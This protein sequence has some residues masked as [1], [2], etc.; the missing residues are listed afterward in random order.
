MLGLAGHFA[1]LNTD[2]HAG[3]G[4][5]DGGLC[6]GT[7]AIG[8]TARGSNGN[9]TIS[10]VEGKC[11]EVNTGIFK[12]ILGTFDRPVEGAR[13]SRDDPQDLPGWGVEG[14]WAFGGIQH[15]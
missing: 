5:D 6:Q 13:A 10:A 7:E 9:N 1:L 8:R 11:F 2:H 4:T 14:W 15:T 12:G 3:E